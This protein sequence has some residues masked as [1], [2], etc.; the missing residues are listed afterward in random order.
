MVQH[1]LTAHFIQQMEKM[2]KMQDRMSG[3]EEEMKTMKSQNQKLQ[4]EVID[5][6]STISGL[7]SDMEG[8]AKSNAELQKE[9]IRLK[10]VVN[11][12]EEEREEKYLKRFPAHDGSDL[13]ER[14]G[15]IGKQRPKTLVGMDGSEAERDR[16]GKKGDMH[17]MRGKSQLGTLEPQATYTS[18]NVEQAD[19]SRLKQNVETNQTQLVKMNENIQTV[20]D[21][22]TRYAIAID[23]VRLRQDVLDVKT[24]H[25]IL[26]WKIPD[27]RRRYRDAME[28]RTI[29]LYSPPFYTSPHGYRMCIRT[30]QWWWYW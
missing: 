29:S 18:F 6:H 23:E 30:Y 12:L 3:M 1:N 11:Q 2:V 20:Q 19:F 17:N 21:S 13:V 10:E 15:V 26:V 16:V 7:R 5:L 8:L 25:G 9:I 28:R 24:T 27:I 14:D 4:S 22:L